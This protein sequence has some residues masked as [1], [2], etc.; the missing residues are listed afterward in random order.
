MIGGPEIMQGQCAHLPD[1]GQR[2]N[3]R[4]Q[5]VPSCSPGMRRPATSMSL[6]NLPEGQDWVYSE[7]LEHGHLTDDPKVYARHSQTCDVLRA[8]SL[9]AP[10]SAALIGEFMEG[11]RHHGHRVAQEQLQ[12]GQRRR[13]HRGQDN[14]DGDPGA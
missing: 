4:I 8:D 7:S 11:Y 2:T 10:E 5:I 12:R 14:P 1:A 13:L 6:I 3:I 9:S